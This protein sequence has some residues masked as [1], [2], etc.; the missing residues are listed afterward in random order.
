MKHTIAVL[1]T[2]LPH[3]IT[4]LSAFASLN[5]DYLKPHDT[6]HA[7][8]KAGS[9]FHGIVELTFA[10]PT[11]SVPVS[12]SFTITGSDGWLS[13]NQAKGSGSGNVLRI[14]IVK[15][16]R[17]SDDG[18]E[19][20]TESE[21]IIE[22][23]MKGVEAELQ[24]FFDAVE[25]KDDLNIGDPVGALRDVAFIQAGLNSAGNSIDLAELVGFGHDG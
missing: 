24:S 14:K 17:M 21:E 12:D 6:I 11:K 23:P 2:V 5:K 22:V 1:R 15:I 19:T 4:H 9:Y 25:G 7:V 3:P 20:E 16:E 8:V 10:S 18:K 13:I